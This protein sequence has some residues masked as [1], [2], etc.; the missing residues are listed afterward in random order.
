MQSTIREE[1]RTTL[2]EAHH[3]SGGP[4]PSGR[5]SC[6]GIRAA[7]AV[8]GGGTVSWRFRKL[9]M[10]LF[11]GSNLDGRIIKAELYFTFIV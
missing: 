2:S 4:I 11:D 3:S 1:V 5:P 9:C 7:G 10:S 8:V 6:S